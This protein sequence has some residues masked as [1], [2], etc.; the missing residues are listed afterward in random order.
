MWDSAR[1]VEAMK[2][3]KSSAVFLREAVGERRVWMGLRWLESQTKLAC[4]FLNDKT[5]RSV[6]EQGQQV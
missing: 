5:V 2:V 4:Y 3:M 6:S 1:C